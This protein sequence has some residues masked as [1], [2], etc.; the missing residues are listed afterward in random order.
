MSIYQESAVGMAKERIDF[1][2][3][4]GD[5]RSTMFYGDTNTNKM[6]RKFRRHYSSGGTMEITE[7]RDTSGN[8]VSTDFTTYI[9]GDAYSAPIILK[10]DGTTQ[11]YLYLHRDN[12]GSILAIS[13][14]NKTMVEQ[15]VFD[16]WGNLIKLINSNGQYVLNN[17]QTLIANY[18][19]FFDRGYTGHEHLLGVGLINMN[20]R[21]YDSKLHRFLMPDN[22]LQD[23]TNS[24]NFNRY[25][26]VLN[27]PLMYVDPSGED[28]IMRE[29]NIPRDCMNCNLTENQ[30]TAIGNT[31]ST[32]VENWDNWGIKDWSNRTF[33]LNNWSDGIGNFGKFFGNNIASA[34][35]FIS[36]NIQSG[37]NDVKGFLNNAL[38]N[39]LKGNKN[40]ETAF[41]P[42]SS[43]SFAASGGTS[44]YVSS[45]SFSPGGGYNNSVEMHSYTKYLYQEKGAIN[46]EV[47]NFNNKLLDRFKGSGLD[48]N[49][50]VV[51]RTDADLQNFIKK[52]DG[53][54]NYYKLAGSPK[55]T[56]HGVSTEGHRGLTVKNVYVY[57]DAF[58]SNYWLASTL[59]HEFSHA[60]TNK[61]KAIDPW[62]AERQAY[63]TEWRLGNR[64]TSIWKWLLFYQPIKP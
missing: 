59:F 28:G 50:R 48:P 49:A 37:I 47:L 46:N 16:A 24:Q 29:G 36:N 14:Q 26:Y 54:E 1:L 53:L 63:A 57:N 20:G 9:A 45:V 8:I 41:A 51:N 33:N 35:N 21:L 39:L 17:G 55:V 58:Q 18:N 27:N 61:Y 13:N 11:N 15:R 25:G 7:I 52:I 10:S 38:N 22:N 44:S 12:L 34:G 64:N 43:Y 6:S 30:Q 32:I 3:N 4:V 2:Y 19:L 62:E 40:P 5:S 42:V 56:D 23:P 31:I 60:Y